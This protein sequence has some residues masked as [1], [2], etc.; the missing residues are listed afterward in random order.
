M[1]KSQILAALALA[2]ALGV[3]MPVAGTYAQITEGTANAEQKKDVYEQAADA[4]AAAAELANIADY[5]TLYTQIEGDNGLAQ[6]LNKITTNEVRWYN[7][8][9]A[10]TGAGTTNGYVAEAN[11]FAS[12]SKL[13][14]KD[15]SGNYV[16]I[17]A[18]V[19]F[20]DAELNKINNLTTVTSINQALDQLESTLSLVQDNIDT[21]KNNYKYNSALAEANYT[22]VES[23]VA[24]FDAL[25][26]KLSSAIDR[27]NE[28]YS[29]GTM[30]NFYTS[31]WENVISAD[32]TPQNVVNL[33]NNIDKDAAYN[34]THSAEWKDAT[35]GAGVQRAN[36]FNLAIAAA[37]ALPKYN[38]VNGVNEALKNVNKIPADQTTNV[39]YDKALEYIATLNNAIEAYK[40]GQAS[41]DN[42]GNNGGTTTPADKEDGNKVPGAGNTGAVA[43][44][45]ATAKAT[46]SIMAA[47]ASVATAAFVAI[48]K[49]AAGKKA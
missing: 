31:S 34:L 9:D 38:F 30:W 43:G 20:N 33:I 40:K 4:I 42:G 28:A 41:T 48:R 18:G 17:K 44:A 5:T 1:K 21:L 46:V 19:S 26:S 35:D 23:A 6:A 45:D 36:Q 11:K 27:I 24:Q 3:A 39:D 32:A 22:Y 2:F 7:E 25:R 13:Y 37:K 15:T 16:Y 12:A 47:I 29:N 49:I 8:N 14:K 10:I